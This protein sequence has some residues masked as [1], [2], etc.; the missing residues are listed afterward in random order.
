MYEV[1]VADDCD[2]GYASTS[3]MLAESCLALVQDREKLPPEGGVLT[4]AT[5]FG[6]V[7]IERLKKSRM[8][9]EFDLFTTD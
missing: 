4:P 1:V 6:S 8:R 9:F 7:L 5:A 2:P 3:K